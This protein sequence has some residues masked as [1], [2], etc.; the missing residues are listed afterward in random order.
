MGNPTSTPDSA[1]T[2]S[3]RGRLSW[4]ALLLVIPVLLLFLVETALFK[5]LELVAVTGGFSLGEFLRCWAADVAFAAAMAGVFASSLSL[6]RRVWAVLVGALFHLTMLVTLFITGVSHGF[7]RATGATF[8][9]SSLDFWL[10]NLGSTSRLVNSELSFARI[11]LVF[12]PLLLWL[13]LIVVPLLP[14]V[15]RRL[16]RMTPLTP[17]RSAAALGA[18]A[19]LFLVGFLIPP[20]QGSAM[21]ISQCVVVDMAKD[22]V[23]ERVLPEERLE[24]AASERLDSGIEVAAATQRPRLNIVFVLFESLTFKASDIYNPG[25]GTTPFLA[26]LAQK[27]W[28]IEHQNAVVPHTTKA[29]VSAICGIYPYLDTE[30]YET[31]PDILPRRCMAHILRSQGYRTGFFSPVANFEHRSQ[32]IANMGFET[33]RLLDD[34]P[35]EGF[36]ETNYFGREERMMLKPSM[37]WVASVKDQPFFLTYLTL[38]S[39]HNYV[40]PQS[41]PYV[42]YPTEDKDQCNYYN[43]VR[44]TDEFLRDV[45][46]ELERMGK[47]EDTV[48][49]IVGDH[50]EAFSEHGRRQHDL[51]LWQ[52]GL[53]AAGIIYNPKHLGGPGRITGQRSHLDLVPTIVEL[54]GLELK[55]GELL[56]QSLLQPPPEG[57]QLFS[58]CWFKRRCLALRE[59]PIKYIYH[60]GLRPME[61]YDVTD[62]PFDLN[63]LAFTGPYQADLLKQKEEAMLR[64]H[65]V[66]NQQYED[67]GQKLT[68]GVVSETE[69]EVANRVEA[70]FGGKIRLVGC[71]VTP[72]T[73]RAG[74]DIQVR[75]VFQSLGE[76]P[77]STAFFVHFNLAGEK[78]FN[79]DHVPGRGAWPM[80]KWEPGK[81]YVDE[82]VIHVPGTWKGGEAR[83]LIGFW[84]KQSKKRLPATTEA[85]VDDHRVEVARVK[86]KRG[87][88]QTGLTLEERRAKASRWLSFERPAMDSALSATFG[89][90]LELL[91]INRTRMDVKLAGTVEMTYLFQAVDKLPAGWRL[92]VKL[93][94]EGGAEVD[95]DHVPI[96]GLYPLGDWREGEF[97]VDR[98]TIHID[99]HRTKPGTYGVWL[100]IADGRKPV[101]VQAEG[102]EVD[103]L[104]RVRLGTVTIANTE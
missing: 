45:Y 57:R 103:S 98:H 77:A 50:G 21:A 76:L 82:H 6:L 18:L 39:H 65:R 55:K 104:Q 41:Y 63:N 43:C 19:V 93:L 90:K 86:V 36:E 1:R 3:P 44:Y 10:R 5:G 88:V 9:Y 29:I 31:T 37:D 38:T 24:I 72:K 32:L 40:P 25:L 7:F 70:D 85:P 49:V 48:F 66:V 59:G 17:M 23:E 8:S 28:V 46:N 2:A 71:D 16:D 56:G 15:R 74:E 68:E 62:D 42:D 13:A 89:G 20:P 79:A 12:V 30:P 83:L 11:L 96:G 4:H 92:T 99:M 33:I 14:R 94:Q 34:M 81:Y 35:W 91:G 75:Y 87:L 22:F 95:G 101:Q 52:E 102:L 61:V 73:I 47:L 54:A 27:G 67:W 97:V 53:H 58:S 26:E 80:E 100:G 60:Y 84:D 69:P 78:F 64:W 51:I